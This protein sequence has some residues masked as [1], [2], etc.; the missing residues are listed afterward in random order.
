MRKFTVVILVIALAC[1]V[2]LATAGCS[3]DTDLPGRSWT[4][5]EVLSYEIYK[6][7]TLYG[8]M[9]ITAERL[10]KGDHVLNA[11]GETHTVTSGAAGGTRVTVMASN[12]AG[13]CIM[14]SESILDGFTSLASYKTVKDG[15]TEYT[16]KA[17]YDGKNYHYSINGGAEKKIKENSSFVDNELLYTIVRCYSVDSGSYSASFNV[18][19]PINGTIDAITATT[20]KTDVYYRGT[21]HVNAE[22]LPV[23]CVKTTDGDGKVTF[24]DSVKAVQIRFQRS[25]A[26]IGTP[27]YVTYAVSGN[28]GLDVKGIGSQNL[29]ST[30][31]PLEIVENDITYKLADVE[32]R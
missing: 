12:L 17:R 29:V 31:I 2:V 3:G 27:V 10:Q 30:H 25:E 32:C 13:E 15:D 1:A 14:R 5:T 6:G 24:V 4:Q 21:T 9:V 20:V 16:V 7:N 26:P 11:T 28:G 19:D 8:A 23:T 18:S 22:N